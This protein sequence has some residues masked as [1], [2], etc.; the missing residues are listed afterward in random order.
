MA[1]FS[2]FTIFVGMN[3]NS[4]KYLLVSPVFLFS[5]QAVAEDYFDVVP[6]V[7]REASG[8]VAYKASVDFPVG[9]D[10]SVVA[11]A[12]N[13]IGEML[14]VDADMAEVP[15][16]HMSPDAFGRL[17]DAVAADYVKTTVKGRREVRIT[18]LYEDPT[19]VSYEAVVTDRDSVEWTT[20]DVAS[21][22][23]K[24]GHRVTAREVFNCDETQIKRLMW[25]Y[26]GDLDME[27]ARP[28]ELYVGNV[29][30]IDGWVIVVG[31]ARGTSGTEYILRYPE[32]ER[33]LVP[34]RGEGYLAE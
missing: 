24:D 6:M 17:L 27:V 23:K 18:W 13:W 8:G 34:A 21:F 26:R 11:A 4:F 14:E 25:Q 33:W 15:V 7:G 16:G 2:F 30:F 20:A 19:C 22:S 28:E 32:I 31:P 9:G 3:A 5:S 10:D 12:K 1:D 29:A